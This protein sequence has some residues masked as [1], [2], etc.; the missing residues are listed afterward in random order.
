MRTDVPLILVVPVQFMKLR[1]CL[2]LKAENGGTPRIT[3]YLW[4]DAGF[5]RVIL[6]HESFDDW[7]PL[8]VVEVAEQPSIAVNVDT[9]PLDAIHLRYRFGHEVEERHCELL[10]RKSGAGQ[11]L[12]SLKGALLELSIAERP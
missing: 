3:S 8:E 1:D 2:F 5:R 11:S 6:H 9:D 12:D 7:S 4:Y 10:K